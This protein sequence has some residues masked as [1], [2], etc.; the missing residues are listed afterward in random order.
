MLVVQDN[1]VIPAVPVKVNLVGEGGAAQEVEISADIQLYS[2]EDY[3]RFA[4][5]PTADTVSG[6]QA[7]IAAN[8]CH[9]VRGW[10]GVVDADK[11]PIPFSEEAFKQ[12]LCSP[13]GPALTRALW[14]K[15][16]QLHLQE[17]AKN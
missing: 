16:H 10:H 14:G 1:V 15:V 2:W 7:E 3:E 17:P 5:P 8:L 6:A 11:Q 9:F 4:A 12:V 13:T